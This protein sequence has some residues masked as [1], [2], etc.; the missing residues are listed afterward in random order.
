MKAVRRLGFTL[1]E[2]SVVVAIIGILYVTIVPMYGKTI[3]R[4]KEAA[5]K[6]DLYVFRKTLDNYFKDHGKWP[7][8]LET[9][10]TE[11]YLRNIPVDPFTEK[12]DTW[13]VIPSQPGMSDVYDVK[14][15]SNKTGLDGKK[16]SEL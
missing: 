1:I 14:S 9:L 5:L 10:V 3:I 2:M 16:Y 13:Q 15:G 7:E 6:Q 4:T 8:S 12:A 11:G